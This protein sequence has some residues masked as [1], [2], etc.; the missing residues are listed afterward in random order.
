MRKILIDFLNNRNNEEKGELLDINIPNY[1]DKIIK[2]ATIISIIKN[3]NLKAF[4]AFYENDEDK[5]SAFLTMIA[6]EKES[7]NLGYGKILLESSI[8]EIQRKGFEFYR[9]EVREGNIKAIKLYE[10]FGFKLMKIELGFIHMEKKMRDE[11]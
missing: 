11:G 9:L 5:L 6:V 10:S 3:G 8:K 1:V 4:I 2:Y 7:A